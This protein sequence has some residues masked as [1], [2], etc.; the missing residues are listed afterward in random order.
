MQIQ[1]ELQTEIVVGLLI[2]N[3]SLISFALP[4]IYA[5]D[6]LKSAT[7]P[8]LNTLWVKLSRKMHASRKMRTFNLK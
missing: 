1:V 4:E 6:D 8:K 5:F 2:S 7:L 3:N